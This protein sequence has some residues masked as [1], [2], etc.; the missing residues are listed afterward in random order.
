MIIALAAAAAAWV[1][2]PLLRGDDD[3]P[4]PEP[5]GAPRAV[6]DAA[7]AALRDFELDYATGKISVEDYRFLRPRYEA[8]ANGA[9]AP[10]PAVR[11]NALEGP[12]PAS[13]P[14]SAEGRAMGG[15][16]KADAGPDARPAPGGRQI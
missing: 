15:N 14:N 13:P 11:A 1:L 5:G 4:P 12:I 9:E 2:L 3:G 6:R 8:R 10:V 16:P 7:H